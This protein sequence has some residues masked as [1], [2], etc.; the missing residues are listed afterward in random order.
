MIKVIRKLSHIPLGPALVAPKTKNKIILMNFG[1]YS[2]TN[3]FVH[4]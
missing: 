4:V 1:N 3:R 2:N